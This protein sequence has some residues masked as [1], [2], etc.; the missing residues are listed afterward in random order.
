MKQVS[1]RILGLVVLLI[2]NLN[3]TAQ[4]DILF[5]DEFDDPI[6]GVK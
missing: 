4:S 5:I 6:V 2:C 1:V 3:A